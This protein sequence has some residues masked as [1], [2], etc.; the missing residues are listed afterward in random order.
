MRTEL[1][2]DALKD[3]AHS[4]HD[5]DTRSCRQCTV[6]FEAMCRNDVRDVRRGIDALAPRVT[7]AS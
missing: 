3:F 7:S 1:V 5:H 6:A 4:A 2:L